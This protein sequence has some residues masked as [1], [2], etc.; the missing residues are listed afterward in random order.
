V[1]WKEG[2][3]ADCTVFIRP[4]HNFSWRLSSTPASKMTTEFLLLSTPPH[5]PP[6]VPLSHAAVVMSIGPFP[7]YP[8]VNSALERAS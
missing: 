3:A 2:A 1:V 5:A 4:P 6:L 8:P 7:I